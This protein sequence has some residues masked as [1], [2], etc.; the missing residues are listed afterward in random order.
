MGMVVTCD[1][2]VYRDETKYKSEILD[3]EI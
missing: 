2:P 3:I 1:V